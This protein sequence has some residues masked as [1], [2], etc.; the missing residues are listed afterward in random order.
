MKANCRGC[1]I[2]Y[3]GRN[4]T[5]GGDI[6]NPRTVDAGNGWQ[7]MV[8][9]F[10]V[11]RKAALVWIAMTLLLTVMWLLML[12]LP[13]LGTML[14]HLFTPVFFAGILIGCRAVE[15]GEPLKIEVLFAGFKSN[16]AALV[17]VG[18]VFLAGSIIIL[19]IV[20]VTAG[21]SALTMIKPGQ[22]PD[23]DTA[24]SIMHGMGPAILIAFTLSLTLYM[25]LLMAIWFAPALI[26]FDKLG[27]VDAMKQSFAACLINTLPFLVYGVVVGILSIIAS[28]PLLLGLLILLPVVY[29]SVYSSYKDI[30]TPPPAPIPQS[31]NPLLK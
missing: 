29:C 12:M 16:V 14:F 19:G 27:A 4:I 7:W 31:G 13:I 21:A 1:P 6:M 9:G 23:I 8:D 15:N 28:I 10:T 26:V 3:N 5:P 18:G 22:T 2:D 30:F 17:S 24:M 25:L 11:F 20:V